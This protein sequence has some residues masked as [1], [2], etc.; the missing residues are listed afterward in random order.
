MSITEIGCCGAYCGTCP[1]LRKQRCLGCKIGYDN[2][3]R[4]LKK[5]KC[6]MK[7]CCMET[8]GLG[9]KFGHLD[10]GSTLHFLFKKFPEKTE[11]SCFIDTRVTYRSARND[12]SRDDSP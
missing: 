4:D 2:G 1:E 5:A 10:S 3:Q 8:G 9:S 7:I 6:K 11:S 12:D